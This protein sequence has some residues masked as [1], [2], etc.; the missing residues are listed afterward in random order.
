MNL[1]TVAREGEPARRL[2]WEKGKPAKC[3]DVRVNDMKW[4]LA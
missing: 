1:C 3:A 4:E 2:V